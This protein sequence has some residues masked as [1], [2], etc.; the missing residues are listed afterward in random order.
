MFTYDAVIDA[1]ENGQRTFINTFVTNEAVAKSMLDIVEA[2]SDF[3]KK[4]AKSTVSAA[5]VVTEE[6]VKSVADFGKFDYAKFSEGVL[7]SFNEVA[8][9][10]KA[11]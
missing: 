5:T 4:T 7:K 10:K 1:V 11:A 6:V 2:Q 3:A 9:K 8:K